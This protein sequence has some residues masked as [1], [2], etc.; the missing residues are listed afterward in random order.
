MAAS[1]ALSRSRG[2]VLVL[3]L[4]IL[5][6]LRDLLLIGIAALIIAIL[7][8]DLI[9]VTLAGVVLT[10]VLAVAGGRGSGLARSGSGRG[11]GGGRGGRGLGGSRSGRGSGAGA[12]A[13]AE[14]SRSGDLVAGV[15]SVRAKEDTGIVSLVEGGGNG[16]LGALS[17]RAS[18]L[19]VDA[20]RV[21]LGTVGGAT[22][23]ESNDLVTGNVVAGSEAGGD[24]RGPAVA[25]LN[26]LL[27]SPLL[28]LGVEASLVNL[29]E[30][31]AGRV[32]SGA[33]TVALGNVGEDGADVGLGPG[34]P[35]PLEL[36]SGG[37]LGGRLGGLGVLVAGN[38]RGAVGIGGD[39]AVVEVLGV[40]AGGLGGRLSL[41]DGVVVGDVVATLLGAVDR[42]GGDGAVGGNGGGESAENGGGGSGLHFAGE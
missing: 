34:V 12:G 19:D 41:R 36:A 37:D 23:V 13:G 22:A 1:H 35:V 20:L 25:V 31:E 6:L 9:L 11:L 24:G 21:V 42:E 29:D 15:V 14:Q 10:V 39:E 28:G 30:L 7:L 26:Q 8:G 32:G 5:V 18:D 4:L 16:T 27:G 33:I 40:P 17:A 2:G 3:A 38:V